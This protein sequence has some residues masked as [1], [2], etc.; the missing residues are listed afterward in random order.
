M[1]TS[2]VKRCFT[3]LHLIPILSLCFLPR[4]SRGCSVSRRIDQ[5]AQADEAGATD[6]SRT[7]AEQGLKIRVRKEVKSR[8]KLRFWLM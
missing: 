5:G 6:L 8:L 3:A 2:I 4:S 7:F 1:L